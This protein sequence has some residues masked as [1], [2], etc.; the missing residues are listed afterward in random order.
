M[1]YRKVQLGPSA[2][3]LSG[4]ELRYTLYEEGCNTLTS[5]CHWSWL[6]R[7]PCSYIESA[8]KSN[9]DHAWHGR[10][11]TLFFF[12][13]YACKLYPLWPA[14]KVFGLWSGASGSTKRWCPWCVPCRSRQTAWMDTVNGETVYD[15]LRRMGG[16]RLYGASHGLGCWNPSLD[17]RGF[18]TS[19]EG[20]KQEWPK[21][22]VIKP[23]KCDSYT[24]LLPVSP[25]REGNSS[26]QHTSKS[27]P[28]STGHPPN[29]PLLKSRFII[30]YI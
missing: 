3:T 21:I 14:V 8:P 17:R 16:W 26:C 28:L 27:R 22:L 10:L 18:S 5:R 1:K 9:F 4:W 30:Y 23:S 29:R 11:R 24:R 6:P 19:W 7:P 13:V 2:L 25:F 12:G 15:V 20:K